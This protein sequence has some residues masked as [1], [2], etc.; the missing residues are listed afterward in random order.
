[1]L[2]LISPAQGPK[3]LNNKHKPLATLQRSYTLLCVFLLC[4]T[5]P[6]TG[7][8]ELHCVLSSVQYSPPSTTE[9]EAHGCVVDCKKTAGYLITFN[10]VFVPT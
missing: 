4:P 8:V 9:S 3:V 1:M 10:N 6:C 2:M 7:R 5:T